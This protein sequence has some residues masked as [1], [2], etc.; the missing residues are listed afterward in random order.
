MKK[1]DPAKVKV[2]ER[3]IGAL[4]K[5]MRSLVK[6][7]KW[8]DLAGRLSEDTVLVLIK[9]N[10]IFRGKTQILKFWQEL[11]ARGL[12]D[13]DF[14]VKK[15]LI[16]P[17]DFLVAQA[18]PIGTYMAYDMKSYLLGDY[19]FT[20]GGEGISKSLLNGQFLIEDCHQNI[21]IPIMLAMILN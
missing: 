7:K 3:G 14:K 10:R 17:A 12:R 21:C 11:G 18:K 2:F 19:T 8:K 4:L 13:V 5:D 20:F 1:L 6:N 9:D 16:V 15:S